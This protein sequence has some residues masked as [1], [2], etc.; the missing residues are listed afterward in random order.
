MSKEKESRQLKDIEDLVQDLRKD[1]DMNLVDLKAQLNAVQKRATR[2][3]TERPFLALAVAFIAGMAI[4]I[5]ITKSS[6]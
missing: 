3:I 6:D 1:V 4:G 2:T 5:A